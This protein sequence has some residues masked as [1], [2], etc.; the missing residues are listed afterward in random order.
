VSGRGLAGIVRALGGDLYA[1]GRRALVPGPGHSHAD[2]SVSLALVDGRV[3]VHAF[4]GDDWRQVRDELARRGLIDWAG[5]L[6]GSGPPLVEI[7]SPP[8]AGARVRLARTLWSEGRPLERSPAARHLQGR[9]V[10]GPWSGE[11]RAHPGVPSVVYRQRGVRRPALL[12][13][14]RDGVGGLCGLEITYL[15]ARG[16]RADLP[17]PRK[18]VGLRPAGSAVRLSEPAGELLVAEGVVSALSAMK[19]LTLPGWALMAAG[20]LARWT[21]PNGVASV[22]IAADRDPAGARAAWRLLRRLRQAGLGC[23][24]VW[25]PAPHRDWNE[26]LLAGLDRTG[27]ERVGP[28]EAEPGTGGAGAADGW[29]G[30]PARSPRP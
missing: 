24:L 1:G 8:P 7:D 20:N 21:P 26:A 9:G 28:R 15:T 3:L 11:L 16:E 18:T 5:R 13:A 2:R 4:A 6:V 25:P 10:P 23:R 29:S 14:I 22:V 12:A 17:V 19:L 30:P 27:G